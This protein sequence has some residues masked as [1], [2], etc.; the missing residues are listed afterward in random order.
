M[1]AAVAADPRLSLLVGDKVG[2]KSW[3]GVEVRSSQVTTTNA[4]RPR[5]AEEDED[6]E[7]AWESRAT[8]AELATRHRRSR[9]AIPI[10]A[11]EARVGGRAA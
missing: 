11:S 3:G 9:G 8:I 2:L 5:A 6:L 4:G 10:S 7:E 1:R